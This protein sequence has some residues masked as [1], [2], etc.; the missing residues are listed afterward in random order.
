MIH[1][2]SSIPNNEFE[3]CDQ[4]KCSTTRQTMMTVFVR[5][6]LS[7]M[8]GFSIVESQLFLDRSK[9]NSDVKANDCFSCSGGSI[10]AG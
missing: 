9:R 6:R 1:L 2:L 4:P 7:R 10:T 5:T 3:H 8:F